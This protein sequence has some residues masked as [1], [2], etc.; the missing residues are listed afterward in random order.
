MIYQFID[1]NNNIYGNTSKDNELRFSFTVGE[2]NNWISRHPIVDLPTCLT[3]RKKQPNPDGS[4]CK[5]FN[6]LEELVEDGVDLE[7]PASLS[8]SASPGPQCSSANC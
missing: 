2:I 3:E 7:S 5:D 8:F 1:I 6:N 4:D